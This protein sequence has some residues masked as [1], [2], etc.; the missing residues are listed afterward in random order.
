MILTA[1][2]SGHLTLP[3]VVPGGPDRSVPTCGRRSHPHSA[4]STR[5]GSARLD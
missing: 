4:G 5:L 1:A 2:M 3:T